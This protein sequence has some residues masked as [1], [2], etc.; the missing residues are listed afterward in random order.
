MSVVN[1]F[2]TSA[3]L[4][5]QG[6]VV[7]VELTVLTVVFSV[8]V[9]LIVAWMRM[10]RL[11]VL[12]GISKAYL[13]LI[14]GT[15]L[16]TQLFVIYYGLV[17]IVDVPAFGAAV[18]GLTLHNAAYMAEIFRSG[19]QSVPKGQTE[20]ARSVGMSRVQAL[21]IVVAPQA[22][23]AILPAL[24]NQI[25]IALKDTSVAS[26]ITV[27]E[28][29]LQA[30]KVAAATYEPLKYYMISAVYYLV[31]VL[32]LTALLRRLELRHARYAI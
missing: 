26:F 11:P 25:I 5:F 12:S 8:I 2:I 4:L 15:P 18:I 32:L 7:M 17:S 20:S 29:F 1:A 9:G 21:R 16:V 23:R 31:I 10:S 19:V 22:F 24:G 14:R 27:P 3:P 28:L 30:Q 6:L 13:G